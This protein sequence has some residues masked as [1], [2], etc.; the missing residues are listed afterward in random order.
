[1]P[2]RAAGIDPDGPVEPFPQDRRT[3][4][5]KGRPKTSPKYRES[6]MALCFTN[7]SRLGRDHSRRSGSGDEEVRP[8]PRPGRVELGPAIV[9]AKGTGDG[10]E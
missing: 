2:R 9:A 10:P 8:L 4:S 7:P 6:E 3:G 1:M 5:G